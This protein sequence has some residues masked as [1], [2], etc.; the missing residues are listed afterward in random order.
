MRHDMVCHAGPHLLAHRD[1]PHARWLPC[2]LACPDLPPCRGQVPLAPGPAGGTLCAAAPVGFVFTDHARISTIWPTLSRR[3]PE[4]RASLSPMKTIIL[5][6]LLLAI[7]L[8]AQADVTTIDRYTETNCH[9]HGRGRTCETHTETMIEPPKRRPP[10]EPL[11][12]MPPSASPR[13]ILIAP[14][15]PDVQCMGPDRCR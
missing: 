7:P 11:H 14:D 1:T 5:T 12:T 6:A 8:A 2:Q 3:R 13:Y 15:S 10:R 9:R 4:H